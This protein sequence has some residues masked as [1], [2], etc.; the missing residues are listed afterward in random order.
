M[1]PSADFSCEASLRLGIAATEHALERDLSPKRRLPRAVDDA[2][3]P[4][5]QA[6]EEFKLPDRALF[7]LFRRR[8]NGRFICQ[9]AGNPVLRQPGIYRRTKNSCQQVTLILPRKVKGPDFASAIAEVFDLLLASPG[10]QEKKLTC[11]RI[12]MHQGM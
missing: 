7:G 10:V 2:H 9:A 11:V 8:T 12:E 5:P 6:A 4:L 3:S 1:R